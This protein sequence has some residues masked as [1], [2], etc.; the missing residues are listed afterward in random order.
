VSIFVGQAKKKGAG[1]SQKKQIEI[2]DGFRQG[3]F[4]V[5]ISTSVGEE[6]LDIPQVDLVIFYEP[7]PSAI[8]KIQRRG[9]TGRLEKGRVVVLIAKDTRD[10]GYKWS[11]HHKEKRMY[12]NLKSLKDDIIPEQTVTLD[13]FVPDTQ[14]KIFADTREKG[15]KIIETLSDEGLLV[16]LK[17][18]DVGDYIL[19]KN[20]AVEFKTK[21]DFVDSL[22]DGR[23]LE[24]I[25]QL[26]KAYPKPLIIVEGEEDIY[27]IRNIHPNAIRGLLATIAVSYSIPIIFTKDNED[28]AHLLTIIAKREQEESGKDFSPH[29]IKPKSDRELQEYIISSLPN[30]GGALAKDLLKNFKTIKNIVNADEKE[31]QQ[32]EKVGNKKA[33]EIK[34][35]MNKEYDG[36]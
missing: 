8:R 5:L 33:K 24:Q 13:K 27:S 4:N 29:S 20:V 12:R 22:I 17:R 32:V 23:L 21:K 34:R 2:L 1:M 10:V 19:S 30:V 16:D 25:K 18:M 28:T 7:V 11:A 9:R 3:E 6:G 36:I 15:S 31:L 14:L 26:K 35:I